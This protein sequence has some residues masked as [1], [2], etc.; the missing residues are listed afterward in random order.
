MNPRR[1]RRTCTC[2]AKR[3]TGGVRIEPR[4]LALDRLKARIA[5]RKGAPPNCSQGKSGFSQTYK[6]DVRVEED[7]LTPYVTT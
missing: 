4:L 2:T 1:R 7:S 3:L 5:A 6:I